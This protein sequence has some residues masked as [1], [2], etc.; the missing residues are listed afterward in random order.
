MRRK[1]NDN[2]MKRKPAIGA[3]VVLLVAVMTLELAI[4]RQLSIQSSCAEGSSKSIGAEGPVSPQNLFMKS[5]NYERSSDF[6]VEE[7]KYHSRDPSSKTS[8][9]AI[10]EVLSDEQHNLIQIAKNRGLQRVD[11]KG[12]ILEILTQAGMEIED[13][14]D[15]DQETLDKLPT[16][17]QIQNLYGPKPIIH[18]LEKCDA[19]RNAVEPR[20]RFFGIAGT[21]NTGTNLVADLL[22][23]NCQITER[24]EIYGEESKGVRWQVPWG[25]HMMA[26]YRESDHTTTTDKDVPKDHI[27]PIISIRDPFSWMQSMC[28]HTYAAHWPHNKHHCPDLI[29][30]EADISIMPKLNKLY[31]NDDQGDL[32]KLIPVDIKYNH[33]LTVHH[34][35]LAH[36]YSEW[37]NDYLKADYPRIMLRFEDMLFY[38]EEVTRTV[39]QCG[40]GVP[41]PNNGRSGRFAHISESAKKGANAHGAKSQRTNLVGALIRYGS[42]ANRTDSMTA[43][44]LAAARRHLDPKLME[45]FGYR[46]PD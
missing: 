27:L 33:E 16:W 10:P 37:Y 19:F 38:G 1:T 26:R 3:I 40:G 5:S 23:F 24:M 20:T 45:A 17:T 34:L 36:Y 6:H 44:D 13:E 15:L 30:T 11:D 25:K 41:V 9:E 42:F 46:H 43:D 7:K 39:C 35:S 18:G 12:P 29:A 2:L 28:R 32:E 31:G 21:F 14:N 4:I 22:K 8:N